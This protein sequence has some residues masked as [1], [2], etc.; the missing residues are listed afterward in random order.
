V[1]RKVSY[2]SSATRP[3]KRSTI[4]EHLDKRSDEANV[5]SVLQVQME[6]DGDGS[7]RQ[8]G[9]GTSGLWPMIHWE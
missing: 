7:T 1:L 6:E 4:K 9:V 5:D 2:D 8:S 3:L